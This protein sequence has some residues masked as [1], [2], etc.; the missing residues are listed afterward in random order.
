MERF[1]LLQRFSGRAVF[2]EVVE[3]ILELGDVSPQ[4]SVLFNQFGV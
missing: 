1:A 2:G 3:P 4:A